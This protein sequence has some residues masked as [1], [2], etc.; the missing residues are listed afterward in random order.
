MQS[1]LTEKSYIV[2]F[3][4][5]FIFEI[6]L[7]ISIDLALLYALKTYSMYTNAETNLGLYNFGSYALLGSIF[8]SFIE[9]NETLIFNRI[10]D[11]IDQIIW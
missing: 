1:K 2:T 3:K 5:L 8:L 9:R 10:V 6:S 11:C 7:K 4:L